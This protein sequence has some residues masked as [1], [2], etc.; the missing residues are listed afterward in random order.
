M[1]GARGRPVPASYKGSFLKVRTSP[2]A[3]LL[4]REFLPSCPASMLLFQ[5]SATL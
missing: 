5:P 4:E 1:Q 2:G 3:P